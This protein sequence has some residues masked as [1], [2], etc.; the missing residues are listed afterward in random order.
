MTGAKKAPVV[1]ALV[2]IL[3]GTVGLELIRSHVPDGNIW[4]LAGVILVYLAG[5]IAG[6]SE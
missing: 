2:S 6:A 3:L 5:A 4:A 1:G